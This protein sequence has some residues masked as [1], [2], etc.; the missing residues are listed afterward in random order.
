MDDLSLKVRE[1]NRVAVDNADCSDACS[2]EIKRRGGAEP[3]GAEDEDAALEELLLSFL[4]YLAYRD[5]PRVP[6]TLAQCEFHGASLCSQ[7]LCVC[8]VPLKAQH[9][10]RNNRINRRPHMEFNSGR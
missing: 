1:I 4:A 10:E 9:S 5:V 3:A 7:S 8:H 6:C 2:G